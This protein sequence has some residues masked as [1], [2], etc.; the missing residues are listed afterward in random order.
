MRCAIGRG[1]LTR[2]KREGDGATPRGSRQ[3]LGWLFRPHPAGPPRGA[4]PARAIRRDA[5][6]CDAPASG[7]YNRPVRLPFAASCEE[8]W[9]ADGKYDAVGVLDY[10]IRPRR[11]GAGSAI[12]FHIADADYGPTAGCLAVSAAD[13]RKLTA[14]LARRAIVRV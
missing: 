12:F 5:G 13:M 9:R 3:I 11:K 2:N 1:G 14:R 8:L 4:L 7:A 10:N 6:W